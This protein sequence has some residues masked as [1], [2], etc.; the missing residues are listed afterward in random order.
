MVRETDDVNEVRG[1]R[2][3]RLDVLPCPSDPKKVCGTV[4]ME[5]ADKNHQISSHRSGQLMEI[6]QARSLAWKI[7][8]GR[9]A[10]L[11][12]I[13]DPKKLYPKDR[14]AERPSE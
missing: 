1:K 3:V 7:A 14:R 9:K 5:D 11:I 6:E 10:D 2:F 8:R 13:D 12:W 4:K